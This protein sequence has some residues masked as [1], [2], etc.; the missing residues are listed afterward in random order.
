MH[1]FGK[2]LLLTL[3]SLHWHLALAQAPTS[4]LSPI[5][6]FQNTPG[7]VVAMPRNGMTVRQDTGV[8]FN[9]M[10]TSG[11]A[12]GSI[13]ASIAHVDG[14]AN[15]TILDLK[16]V[17]LY[18]VI[19]L[20]NTSLSSFPPGD[21]HIQMIITPNL[22]APPLKGAPTAPATTVPTSPAPPST[23]PAVYYWR[24]LIR[25]ALPEESSPLSSAASTLGQ[26]AALVGTRVIWINMNIALGVLF[27]VFAFTL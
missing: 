13:S 3:L 7:V 6:S 14:S 18:R 25:L 1:A 17:T 2:A 9:V 11:R 15:T 16:Q 4:T 26:G 24:G 22:S 20:R 8:P 10:L 19:Q 12:V 27:V 21:Y 5:P 23:A